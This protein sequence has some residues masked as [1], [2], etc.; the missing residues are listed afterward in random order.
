M[1]LKHLI[2]AEVG[3]V[4][5]GSF[6]N[7]CKLIEA[8]ANCGADVIKFQTH[9][10]EYETLDDAPAPSYFKAESRME[11]FKRTEFTKSQWGQIADCCHKN[12]VKFVSSPF[13]IQAVQ[14]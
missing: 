4:H 6:G 8:A 5:D 7:A 2:M 12:K 3:S 11:Y 9:L 14:L 1:K 10:A 13:S